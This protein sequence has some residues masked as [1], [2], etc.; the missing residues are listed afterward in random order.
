MDT[1]T[2]NHWN[3]WYRSSTNA[4]STWSPETRLSS[5][6]TGYD[7]IFT[8]GFSS[9]YGDYYEMDIDNQGVTHVVWGEGQSYSGHGSVWYS[10]GR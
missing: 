8:D 2:G 4:G 10:K 1:R 7:Y 6:V 5:N 3:T 9:P